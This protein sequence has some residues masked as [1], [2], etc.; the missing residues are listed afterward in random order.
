LGARDNDLI[1]PDGGKGGEQ[2]AGP[3]FTKKEKLTARGVVGGKPRLHTKTRPIGLWI[4]QVS[5]KRE[6]EKIGR[7]GL[8]IRRRS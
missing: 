6:V 3:T 1:R 2:R 8:N 4:M 7:D 5:K